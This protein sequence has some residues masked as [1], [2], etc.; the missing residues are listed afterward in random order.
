MRGTNSFSEWA[1]LNLTEDDLSSLRLK[2]ELSFAD[3][4]LGADVHNEP[5][6]DIRDRIAIADDFDTSPLAGRA[7]N[8]LFAAKSEGVFPGWVAS[9]PIIAS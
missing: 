3:R 5:V 2:L 7:F 9:P 1:D 6:D 8:I 4:R